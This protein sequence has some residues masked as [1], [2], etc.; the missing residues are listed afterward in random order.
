MVCK[1]LPQD[2]VAKCHGMVCLELSTS[3][4]KSAK[5]I[6]VFIPPPVLYGYYFSK[7]CKKFLSE[8]STD[9]E[10]F[11]H[12]DSKEYKIFWGVLICHLA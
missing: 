4:F 10:N 1:F 12:K 7:N 11:W 9:C 2:T 8:I 6:M 5:H 3:I